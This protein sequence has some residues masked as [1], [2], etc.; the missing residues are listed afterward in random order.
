MGV[1][2]EHEGVFQHAGSFLIQPKKPVLRER[3]AATKD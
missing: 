2:K 3:V 1:R